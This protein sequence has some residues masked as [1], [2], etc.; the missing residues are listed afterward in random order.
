MKEVSAPSKITRPNE[1][2]NPLALQLHG[3]RCWL[4][5]SRL[6]VKRIVS[7]LTATQVAS[8]RIK[9]RTGSVDQWLYLHWPLYDCR[10]IPG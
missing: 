5:G 1:I 8:H 6:D 7:S 10:A 3:G 2:T 4:W 9:N